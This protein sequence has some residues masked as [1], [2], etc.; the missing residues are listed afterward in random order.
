MH[1]L[2][3]N[4]VSVVRENLLRLALNS[5]HEMDK[6]SDQISLTPFPEMP[7]YLLHVFISKRLKSAQ[8][9]AKRGEN[10]DFSFFV[11]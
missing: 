3:E 6:Y 2:I 7:L 10:I 8:I 5:S 1:F 9:K 11:T 4:G